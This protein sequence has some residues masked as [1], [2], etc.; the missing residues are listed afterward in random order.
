MA[1]APILS[2]PAFSSAS[3]GVSDG[4][5]V[6]IGGNRIDKSIKLTL[7]SSSEIKSDN[8]IGKYS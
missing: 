5:G 3:D 7:N 2:C 8:E 6:R 4:V 1:S